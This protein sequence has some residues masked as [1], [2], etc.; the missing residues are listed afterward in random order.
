[1]QFSLLKL[2]LNRKEV[3]SERNTDYGEVNFHFMTYTFEK[4]K[5]YVII[6]HSFR[7]NK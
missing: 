1:M 4:R 6:H 2:R 7:R 3:K 5:I